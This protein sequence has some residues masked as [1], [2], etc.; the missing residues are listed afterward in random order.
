MHKLYQLAAHPHFFSCAQRSLLLRSILEAPSTSGGCELKLARLEK[1]NVVTQIFALHDDKER[2]VLEERWTTESSLGLGAAPITPLFNY[3][4]ADVTLYLAFLRLYS[5]CLWAPA[6]IGLVLFVFQETEYAGRESVFNAVF[7]LI[8]VLWA[9]IFLQQWNRTHAQ[10][11]HQWATPSPH[12]V[13]AADDGASGSAGTE[14]IEFKAPSLKPGFYLPSD[15]F[16]GIDKTAIPD[17][18]PSQLTGSFTWSERMLRLSASWGVLIL[19]GGFSI[20]IQL[21]L[22]LLRSYIIITIGS[23]MGGQIVA[24]LAD[25]SCSGAHADGLQPA[26]RV[27]P[28]MAKPPINAYV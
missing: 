10:L 16:V 8:V 20:L 22:L 6:I 28:V 4:G 27:P 14:R 19:C 21:A 26:R 13:G 1:L 3:F 7:S 5:L 24:S 12:E 11:T 15:H 18:V 9:T 23:P 25:G 2:Q 17:G